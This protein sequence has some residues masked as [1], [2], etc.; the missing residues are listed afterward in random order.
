MRLLSVG[1]VTA[2]FFYLPLGSSVETGH[3]QWQVFD[4]AAATAAID[5]GQPVIIDFYADWCA[6]CRELDE[7]TFSDS[8]VAA[9]LADYA[10]FKVD[11]T[12]SSDVGDAAATDYQVMGM[13]TVIVFEG[14]AEKFRI[15]GFEPPEIFLKRLD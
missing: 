6:P 3:L 14:G 12:R 2:G 15:T 10:R 5:S 13:P 8:R 11:Q 7:L 4:P 1:M 9:V